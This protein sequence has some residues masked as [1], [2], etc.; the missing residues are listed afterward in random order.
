MQVRG[1][2]A[3]PFWGSY[4]GQRGAGLREGPKQ[5][6]KEA[7]SSQAEAGNGGAAPGALPGV[8]LI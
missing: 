6:N 3:G 8:G 5:F 7:T 2:Q 4:S 1:G